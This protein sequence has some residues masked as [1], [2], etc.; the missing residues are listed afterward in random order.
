MPKKAKR[1]KKAKK[2]KKKVKKVKRKPR[3]KPEPKAQETS[4]P[5]PSEIPHATFPPESITGMQPTP[6]P[7]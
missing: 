7:M 4:V 2:A 3:P 5:P 1:A 6:P